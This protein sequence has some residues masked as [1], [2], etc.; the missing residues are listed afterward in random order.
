MPST[1]AAATLSL[2]L[3]C[4]MCTGVAAAQAEDEVQRVSAAKALK[5][6]VEGGAA[7]IQFTQHLDLTG[8]PALE[9]SLP[10]GKL[11]N[12]GSDLRSVTVRIT[13]PIVCLGS[14]ACIP[15]EHVRPCLSVHRNQE[16]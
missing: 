10:Y 16:P 8:L 7:H 12:P 13:L 11:F 15:P 9:E 5:Q 14:K 2:S 3:L 6:A 4:A 1:W